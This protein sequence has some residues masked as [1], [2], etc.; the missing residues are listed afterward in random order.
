MVIALIQGQFQ[1]VR[2]WLISTGQ[3]AQHFWVFENFDAIIA[4]TLESYGLKDRPF[5]WLFTWWYSIFNVLGQWC[6]DFLSRACR[7]IQRFSQGGYDIGVVDDWLRQK[8]SS[9]SPSKR[10]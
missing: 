6:R 3:M 8:S 4:I 9:H 5:I 10:A 7:E 1:A 2:S